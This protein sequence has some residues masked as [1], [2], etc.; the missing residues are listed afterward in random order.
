MKKNYNK[1]IRLRCVVC[2]S[3]SDFE[4]NEDKT[5]I[6]CTKCNR[7]YFGGYDE[8][9]ELNKG[10]IDEEIDK[11]KDEIKNDVHD[12]LAAMLNKAFKGNRHIKIK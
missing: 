4:S 10:L 5:Y 2:G 9:V 1:S 12:E 7:E 3:D 6:K 8:L 11:T